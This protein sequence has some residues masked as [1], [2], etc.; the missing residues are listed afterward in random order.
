[1]P[2]DEELDALINDT[3][4]KVPTILCDFC[5]QPKPVIGFMFGLPIVLSC[6]RCKQHVNKPIGLFSEN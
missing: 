3:Q 2:E 6:P 5:G 4:E 1:M